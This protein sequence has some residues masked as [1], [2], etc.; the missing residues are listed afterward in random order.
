M[1]IFKKKAAEINAL[2]MLYTGTLTQFLYDVKFCKDFSDSSLDIS[3]IGTMS[4][5]EA[6]EAVYSHLS[7]AG[8]IYWEVTKNV[9]DKIKEMMQ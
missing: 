5:E 8:R 2:E 7:E 6:F 9:C 1:N 4:N 3:I